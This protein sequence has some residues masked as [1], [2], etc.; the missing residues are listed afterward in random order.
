[1]VRIHTSHFFLPLDPICKTSF[2]THRDAMRTSKTTDTTIRVSDTRAI[3]TVT[4][5]GTPMRT[6]RVTDTT[7]GVTDMRVRTSDM[8]IRVATTTNKA[9]IIFDIIADMR[10]GVSDTT[11][12][13]ATTTNRVVIVFDIITDTTNKVETTTIRVAMRTNRT[14]ITT[15]N[16]GADQT[17]VICD[18]DSVIL[19]SGINASYNYSWAPSIGL[20][21]STIGNPTA[22]PIINTFY[23]LDIVD[24]NTGCKSSDTTYVSVLNSNLTATKTIKNLNCFNDNSGEV[25]ISAINGYKPYQY[26]TSTILYQSDSVIKNLSA[27][28]KNYF[29]I[30]AKGCEY[31]DSFTLIEPAKLSVSL[32]SKKDL[33][34]YNDSIGEIKLTSIG[35]TP[36]YNY[37]WDQLTNSTDFSSNL[38]AGDYK[39]KV[40]DT[41]LCSDL[42]SVSLT[43][44]EQIKA[45]EVISNNK[46]S[47]D[48]SAAITLN[49]SKGTAPYQYR[50]NNGVIN[51]NLYN[52]KAGL[53]SIT[54]T[55]NNSCI[56]SFSYVLADPLKI[57]IDTII[58]KGLKCSGY[59]DGEIYIAASGGTKP[60][61]YSKD[62]GKMYTSSSIFKYLESGYYQIVVKD[63]NNCLLKSSAFIPIQSKLSFEISP[64]DTQVNL[65]ESVQLSYK[66]LTGNKS[67]ISSIL[68]SPSLGLSCTDCESPVA[69]T[70]V[71]Q[72][73]NL[74]IIYNDN[75]T[76]ESKTKILIIPNDEI[77]VPNALAPNSDEAENRVLRVYSKNILSAHLSIFNRWGEKVYESIHANEEGWDGKYK[78]E[79]CPIGVYAYYLE[80]T[81]LDKRKMIKQG[82]IQLI[83]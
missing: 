18:G 65:G 62:S 58:A 82:H 7:I 41:K 68:W 59:Q 37:E 6:I 27:G 39:I 74:K 66:L 2:T 46:C 47:G 17:R 43:Q 40:K 69:S 8:R 61:F 42:L 60:L 77:F 55:D 64:K 28:I 33:K 56:N 81:F 9:V 63:I 83:R 22:K 14:A 34:C 76:A 80:L 72:L 44:P 35:G 71:N 45:V 30:D 52:L 10:I 21:N 12:R 67:M 31:K 15:A 51:Q 24:K 32:V 75:C 79:N 3:P 20:D 36:P 5:I 49:V 25:K 48:S 11:I 1:M 29:V 16:A 57:K 73:Y 53:Y 50:W 70:Y 38:K 4:T 78:N 13:T 54:I 19:G 23:T 26:K